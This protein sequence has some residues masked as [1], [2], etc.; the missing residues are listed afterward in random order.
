[1]CIVGDGMTCPKC[2]ASSNSDY[3][4][5]CGT[6]VADNETVNRIK[7]NMDNE[8]APRK[9]SK[10]ELVFKI[11]KISIIF[12]LL[13]FLF[14]NYLRPIEGNELVDKSSNLYVNDIYHSDGMMHNTL[15]EKEK[16]MY[17]VILNDGK[18]VVRTRTLNHIEYD[19]GSITAAHEAIFIDQPALFSHGSL[20]A[21]GDSNGITIRYK[22]AMKTKF[23]L[24]IGELRI[25]RIIDDIKRKTRNM[26]EYE[27][28]KYVY[29]YVGTKSYSLVTSNIISSNQSAWG[30]FVGGS[31]VCAG[32][33][34]A[35]QII[36]QNIGIESYIALGYTSG[37]HA[38]NIVKID[39]DYYYFDST[40][41]TAYKESSDYFY[42]GIGINPGGYSLDYSELYPEI[43]GTKYAFN[44]R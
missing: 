38:W 14:W 17:M 33:A 29:E 34:K 22:R 35:S 41:A 25:A 16:K 2:G 18:N 24:K 20:S 12:S 39:G 3:C 36:F 26:S 13:F 37:P 32:F 9:K 31:S 30:V 23:G 19:I 4:L 27:K 43:N 6:K 8:S 5:R 15:S 40:V 44:R 1:M 11:L 42:S 10:T 28:V 21:S 7:N